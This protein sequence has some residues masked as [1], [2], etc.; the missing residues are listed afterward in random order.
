MIQMQ[1]IFGS[2]TKVN[3]IK[4]LLNDLKPV[5]RQGF[6][7]EELE[8]VKQFCLQNNLFIELSPYK[9]LMQG[10]NFSDKG[11]KVDINHPKGM[12]FAYISKDHQKALLANLHETKGD[13]RK[14]GLILGYPACCVRFYHE[15]FQ[16]GNLAP[17]FN[18]YHELID[19]RKRKTDNA[20]ISHF[21]C[22]PDCQES[23]ELAKAFYTQL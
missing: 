17:E 1:D 21:P 8:K 11:T 22:K 7:P 23:I 12:F 4:L 14:L 10:D 19:I 2:K 6:Y 5:V 18:N 13:H 3:E 15:Q 16:K 9:I 20:I